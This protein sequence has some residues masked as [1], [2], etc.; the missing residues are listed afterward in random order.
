MVS[1]GLVLVG[2]LWAGGMPLRYFAL[3][4]GRGRG[5]SSS[6][7]IKVAPYRMARITSFIDPFSDPTDGGFQAIRGMY[8]LATG[9]LWGVGPGQQRDE[10]EPAAAR[11]VGLHLRDHRRGAGLPRLPRRRHPVR[12]ARLRRLPHRPPLGRPVRP[13]RLRRDH[14]LA[15]RPGRDEHGL[16]RRPAAGHRRPAAADLRGRHLAGAHPLHR[17]PARPV[18]PLRARG[19]RGAARPQPAGAWPGSSCRSRCPPWT[20]VRPPAPAGGAAPRPARGGRRRPDASSTPAPQRPAAGRRRAP[21][22][23]GS[24]GPA[25]P[26]P[27]RPAAVRCP[28]RR[29]T[30]P[31][32]G[33]GCG[34]AGEGLAP[35]VPGAPAPRGPAPGRVAPSAC[36]LRA[37]PAGPGGRGER[38]AL[39]RSASSW[40]E[41]APRGHIEPMLALADA[42]RRRGRRRERRCGSPAWA[43]PAAWRPAWSRPA[44]TTCG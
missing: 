35:R 1:L 14:R 24:R 39:A 26:N 30:P 15:D 41:A 33:G 11:A 37:G 32:R 16:R 7:M 34:A 44:A 25:P 31:P 29:R 23:R 6:L 21:R 22:A 12:R 2:L 9:G 10:V 8:A 18:R 17:R 40:P 3:V 20:P 5:R 4:R 38:G 42:L 43:P 27:A 13:A 28:H 19:H 36:R